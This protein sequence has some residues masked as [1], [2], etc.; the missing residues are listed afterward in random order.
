LAN[1]RDPAASVRE[2][3]RRVIPG[4]AMLRPVEPLPYRPF[5]SKSGE[6]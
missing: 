6:G 2:R 3:E 5:V 4:Y 1:E